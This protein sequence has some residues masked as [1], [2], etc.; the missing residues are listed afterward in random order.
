[1]DIT[2]TELFLAFR[3]AKLGLNQE[4]RGVGRISIAR[5]Q[6]R[7]D[8]ILTNLGRQLRQGDDWFDSARLGEVLVVPKNAP[9][10]PRPAGLVRVGTSDI[11]EGILDLRM[12]LYPTI[13]FAIIEILWLWRFGPALDALTSKDVYSNRLQVRFGEL[14][15]YSRGPFKYWRDDYVNFRERAFTEARDRLTRGGR[16]CALATFLISP[17]I[18]TTLIRR[19]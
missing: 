16:E 9:R 17:I 2:E 4:Q 1:M 6:E 13:E 7:I 19:F 12:H 10:S 5:S 3:Q 11:S 14:D 18:T 8:G 15:R